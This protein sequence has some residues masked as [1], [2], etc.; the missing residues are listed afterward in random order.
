MKT[1]RDVEDLELD[2]RGTEQSYFSGSS[3][4]RQ[5]GPPVTIIVPE[6][7]S[8]PEEPVRPPRSASIEAGPVPV[9]V[10]EL[11]MYAT[12]G[13][14]PALSGVGRKEPPSA[15]PTATTPK[16]DSMVGKLRSWASSHLSAETVKTC[17][18]AVVAFYLAVLIVLIRPIAH[19][20]GTT[21]Y[22]APIAVLLFSPVKTVG[23]FSETILICCI[24]L[25][26]GSAITVVALTL[27][28]AYSDSFDT[29]E[30]GEAGAALIQIAFLVMATFMLGYVRASYPRLHVSTV[31]TALA[32]AFP[33]TTRAKTREGIPIS[34][35]AIIKPI[36]AGGLICLVT[37]LLVFPKFS[38]RILKSSIDDSVKEC[39]ELL[40]MIV[41]SFLKAGTKDATPL[42]K[43]LAKQETVR[44]AIAK[45]KAARRECQYEVTYN[46][47]SPDDY[48]LLVQPLQEMMKYLSGMVACV[49]LAN[50]LMG[51][52]EV[53]RN[54][55]IIRRNPLQASVEDSVQSHAVHGAYG[56]HLDPI[57]RR[58]A[59]MKILQHENHVPHDSPASPI[60]TTVRSTR[61]QMSLRSIQAASVYLEH[62]IAEGHHVQ[63]VGRE[64]TR[65]MYGGCK[66]LLQQYLQSVSGT[67]VELTSAGVSCLEYGNQQ[68]NAATG[69]PPGRVSH[70]FQLLK[71]SP[72][73]L[74]SSRDGVCKE[75]RRRS[76][77]TSSDLHTSNIGL[78]A[79]KD[80][81]MY[82]LQAAIRAFEESEW[83]VMSR[84]SHQIDPL[85]PFTPGGP[86]NATNTHWNAANMFREEYFLAAFFMF[87][88]KESAS[89][90]LKFVE[91]VEEMRAKR[92]APKR[93]WRPDVKF[94]K[95]AMGAAPELENTK[96]PDIAEF[97]EGQETTIAPGVMGRV[98]WKM[99]T[100][101]KGFQTHPM[102]F[103]F[104]MSLATALL[105]WPAFVWAD[106]WSQ[107]RGTWALVTMLLVISPSVGASVGMGLYRTLAGGIYGYLTWA[108]APENPYVTTLLTLLWAFPNFYIFT[109]TPHARLGTAA[110]VTFAV[111]GLSVYVRDPA[112][113]G[114]PV[115]LLAL[116]RMMTISIGVCVALIVTSYFWPF[117]ARIELRIALSKNVYLMSV[118]CSQL[119]AIVT[120]SDEA[121]S[122]PSHYVLA[123]HKR[124][125]LRIRHIER[126]LA[127][128]VTRQKELL[129]MTTNEPR[130]KGPFAYHIVKEIITVEQNLVERLGN[131]RRIVDGEYA[132]VDGADDHAQG[133]VDIGFGK[134]VRKEILMPV[135]KYRIDMFASLLLYLHTLST[136]LFTKTPL[137][138]FLPPAR[139]ARLRLFSKIRDLPLLRDRV[140][141]DKKE[142]REGYIKFMAYSSAMED[143]IEGVEEMGGLVRRWVGQ[144]VAGEG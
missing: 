81:P 62:E 139:A 113:T 59:A 42:E 10:H 130:L 75:A 123:R 14:P 41:Q 35:W 28:V 87:N 12:T 100:F 48:K 92:V 93:F 70:I 46:R 101:F 30:E 108:I 18:K 127:A 37:N 118:L 126:A 32:L 116:K 88:M 121:A 39:T 82:T 47:Y 29:Y 17:T 105:A 109:R 120:S 50:E 76:R 38:G 133:D 72:S 79:L 8:S 115:I 25:A 11:P 122:N 106:W 54:A 138:P 56:E 102:R 52:E 95:W 131:I 33:M 140:L 129:V 24:G 1:K 7:S 110:L 43:L 78:F 31:I 104:K 74:R 3:R 77:V 60:Q 19:D 2:E 107:W 112:V 80:T 97:T 71:S 143:L 135:D 63:I 94:G 68:M 141:T 20:F 144:G 73:L 99:W 96:A 86:T 132:A 91:G 111:V 4:Q 64:I 36:L 134:F 9:G 6:V 83:A 119:A 125:R 13:I 21:A 44:A 114:D 26:L 15:S 58:Q 137:P 51:V 53:T 57:S 55:S 16:D 98:R 117:V 136:S 69:T 67:L 34:L 128:S 85:A 103:G 124:A 65:G 90:V 61:S 89:K 5:G 40:D 27:S 84:V 49:K 45:T 22:L 66:R 23:A 142:E